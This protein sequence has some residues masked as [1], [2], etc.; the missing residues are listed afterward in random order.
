MRSIEPLPWVMSLEISQAVKTTNDLR[1]KQWKTVVP[2]EHFF[3]LY[4]VVPSWIRNTSRCVFCFEKHIFFPA[5]F[6]LLQDHQTILRAWAAK[7]FAPNCPLY[8]QILKPENKFHV[9]FAGKYLHTGTINTLRTLLN[10][11]DYIIASIR[12]CRMWRGVQICHVGS[13]LCVSGHVYLSHT[14]GSHLQRTVSAKISLSFGDLRMISCVTCIIDY[15]GLSHSHM[16]SR[17]EVIDAP[18]EELLR[19]VFDFIVQKMN[20]MNLSLQKGVTVKFINIGLL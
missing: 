10:Q 5:A 4:T 19:T 7:D 1:F 20:T 13:E 11:T 9:K 12:S 8:V 17:W 15:V 3:S 6:L 2:V 16:V 14:P 18:L